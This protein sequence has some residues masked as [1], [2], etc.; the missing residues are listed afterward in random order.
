M[1]VADPRPCAL[2]LT[3]QLVAATVLCAAVFMAAPQ[4]AGAAPAVTATFTVNGRAV[5]SSS[6][7]NPIKLDPRHPANVG[8]QVTNHGSSEVDVGSVSLS[9]RTLGLPFVSFQTQISL[10]VPPGGV[11][12]E[13][14]TLDLGALSGQGDG[15]IPV[16]FQVL[17]QNGHAL[18]GQSFTADVRGRLSSLFGLIAIE[19]L[20]LA[21]LLFL[22]AMIAL[23]RGRLHP[24][25]WR[26]GI[27]FLWVGLTFGIV[28]VFALAILR[29]FAPNPNHSLPIVLAFSAIG[30]VLGYLT[31]TPDDEE[32]DDD[33]FAA[34]PQPTDPRFRPAAAHY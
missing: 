22:G 29:V 23:A 15:L 16:S 14:I 7:T 12:S 28:I 32:D 8:I 1:T 34:P 11:Q 30:F 25:R 2:R 31:P 3:R 18:A 17:D 20:V 13:K 5:A 21:A 33:E 19:T 4:A 9:G 6:G 27:R 10:Q 24:N 26:R